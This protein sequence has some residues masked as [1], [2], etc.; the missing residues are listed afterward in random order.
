MDVYDFA[1]LAPSTE[2]SWTED[3][4][5]TPEPWM[6]D[7]LCAQVGGDLHFPQ[8]AE[9]AKAADAKRI[10]AACPVREQCLAFALRTG[11]R[12]GIWG[13]LTTH[14]RRAIAGN[15]RQA[16]ARREQC[17][18]GHEFTPENTIHTTHKGRDGSIQPRRK[19][20]ECERLRAARRARERAS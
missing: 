15:R 4:L 5:I 11:E 17:I 7:A 8:K 3:P 2:V 20:R 6:Q 10:C 9:H 14:E 1:R 19:C 13:G 16:P 12:H 18:H